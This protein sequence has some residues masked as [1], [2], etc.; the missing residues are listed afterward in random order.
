MHKNVI[1]ASAKRA[2][3]HFLNYS[4]GMEESKEQLKINVLAPGVIEIENGLNEAEQIFWTDYA[5]MC[6]KREKDGF[7]IYGRDG[8]KVLNFSMPLSSYGFALIS[9]PSRKNL[10]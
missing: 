5:M 6:G 7:Y 4:S 3:S 1:H 8:K 2:R 10:R 9:S